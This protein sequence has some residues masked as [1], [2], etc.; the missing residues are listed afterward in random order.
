MFTVKVTDVAKSE[1]SSICN[2]LQNNLGSNKAKKNFTS[3]LNK[4]VANLK[5]LPELYS[6]STRPEISKFDGRVAPVNNY[7]LIYII[8][9][10]DVIILHVFHSSQD[11]GRLV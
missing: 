11:Y 6:I 10:D 3:K 1:I 7:V 4:Q 9:D 2:Y 5:E 8:K